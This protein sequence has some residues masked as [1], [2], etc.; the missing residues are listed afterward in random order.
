MGP[1]G[2]L[3]PL[4]LLLLLPPLLWGEH[5]GPGSGV[6][7]AGSQSLSGAVAG[8]GG[9]RTWLQPSIIGGREAK[10]HSRPYMVSLQ[11]GGVH[12][13]GAALVHR[14]WALTAAHCQRR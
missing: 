10:N 3:G 11:F 13:C 14:S 1:R 4:L 2:C 12:S 6:A 7:R 5:R 8:A 9:D